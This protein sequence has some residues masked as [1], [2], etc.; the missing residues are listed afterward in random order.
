VAA[1]VPGGTAA[2]GAPPDAEMGQH[3]PTAFLGR[4]EAPQDAQA[5]AWA[6]M[7]AQ[8]QGQPQPQAQPPVAVTAE[9]VQAAA[10]AAGNVYTFG[11]AADMAEYAPMPRISSIIDLWA[12]YYIQEVQDVIDGTW[13]STNTWDGIGAGMVGIGEISSAV[14]ADVKAKAEEV[15]DA[16]AAGTLHPFTGPLNHQDGSPWLADGEVADDGT[17]AGM[18]F[19]VEGIQGDIPK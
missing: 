6:Q 4:Q 2:A 3:P 10:A 7:Q 18:N 14:P 13:E 11:Q 17:L 12:P 16:I 8:M 1:G 5:Q 15:R 9:Q 19:Y